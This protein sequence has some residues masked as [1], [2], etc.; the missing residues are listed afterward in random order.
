MAERRALPH[1]PHADLV[2]RALDGERAPW[3]AACA[4]HLSL[5]RACRERLTVYERA[6]AAGRLT[7]P[8]ETLQAPPTRVWTALRTRLDAGRHPEPPP[9]SP[10]PSPPA[11][12][13]ARRAVAH[14]LRAPA[15]AARAVLRLL[16]RL[17]VALFARLR[18]GPPREPDR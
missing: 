2:S 10:S 14:V 3:D 9:P 5:C 6:A 11:V 13:P 15:A 12:H 8:G 7:C 4:R 17:P 16:V 18:P 1:I